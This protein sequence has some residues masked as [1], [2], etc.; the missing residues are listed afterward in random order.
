MKDSQAFPLEFLNKELL[1]FI[2]GHWSQREK[3]SA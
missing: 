3:T 1:Q 2:A